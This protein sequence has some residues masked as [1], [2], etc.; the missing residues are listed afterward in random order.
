MTNKV[1]RLGQAG[2]YKVTTWMIEY[3]TKIES[4][5]W[6]QT[7]TAKQAGKIL[8]LDVTVNHIKGCNKTAGII[9]P[10]QKPKGGGVDVKVLKAIHDDIA[11][12]SEVVAQS[13]IHRPGMWFDN[14]EDAD[15]SERW[16]LTM[17][18]RNKKAARSL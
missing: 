17:R 2:L 18:D 4:L 7:H 9:W 11:S 10:N 3:K 6:T 13:V 12:L 5:G 1:N 8:G 16:L 14:Q 15:Q